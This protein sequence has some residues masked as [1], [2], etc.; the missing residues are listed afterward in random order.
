MPS[1]LISLPDPALRNRTKH[2]IA[3]KS[4]QNP[5]PIERLSV[6]RAVLGR[7]SPHQGASAP[8]GVNRLVF[9]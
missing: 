3:F 2:E 6:A 4:V 1:K 8:S 5:Y 7:Q 9:Q